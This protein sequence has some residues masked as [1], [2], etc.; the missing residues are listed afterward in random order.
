MRRSR[1]LLPRTRCLLYYILLPFRTSGQAFVDADFSCVGR[2]HM[3]RN[4]DVLPPSLQNRRL[5][6]LISVILCC[7]LAVAVLKHTRLHTTHTHTPYRTGSV[8]KKRRKKAFFIKYRSY[9]TACRSRTRRVCRH[10][11]SG[12]CVGLITPTRFL[13]LA[14][15]SARKGCKALPLTLAASTV[16]LR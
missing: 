11:S 7:L 8:R 10:G 9:L 6:S 15:R 3:A 16:S 2:W 13:T 5:C 4:C 14:P 12:H 1:Y